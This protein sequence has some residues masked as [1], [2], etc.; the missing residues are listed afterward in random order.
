MGR[1][2]RAAHLVRR[3]S[4]LLCAA[5]IV[6]V[7]G[8]VYAAGATVTPRTT[9]YVRMG[10]T[11]NGGTKW[12]TRTEFA[13]LWENA[14]GGAVSRTVTAVGEVGSGTLGGL[15]RKAV[16][17]G[18]YGAAVGLAVEGIVKGAGW[19][20]DE[21]QHQVVDAPSQDPG[22]IPAGQWAYTCSYGGSRW[23][24]T[25]PGNLLS[26][27]QMGVSE[28]KCVWQYQ[29]NNRFYCPELGV[30]STSYERN[31][32]ATI[33]YG[34]G[35]TPTRITDDQLGD[36]LKDHPEVVNDL[37]IDPRTGAPIMTPEL[38]QQSDKIKQDIDQRE[39][40]GDGSPNPVVTPP[41]D[42]DTAQPTETDWPSFC[43]WAN[44]V[45]DFI[46]WVKKDDAPNKEPLP[47]RELDI[48]PNSWTSGVGEGTCPSPQKFSITVTG[49][50]ASG[51]YSFQPLCDF[52][53]QLKPFLIVVASIV[54]VMILAGLRSTNAK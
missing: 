47:E 18:V 10:Q 14:L 46:D 22:T 51:E 33:D 12:G 26:C 24:S 20:I 48:N 11:A 5:L 28:T 25:D 36:V 23:W 6:C 41:L 1:N 15:A 37:L 19:A 4:V 7:V 49:Y 16:R 54:A 8:A 30:G 21:L 40:I 27:M 29:G 38:Q 52:A 17:G 42:D 31:P 53:S 35:H 9:G 43:G 34:T 32:T 45:C 50:A 13:A 39:G 44:V 2:A 3:L